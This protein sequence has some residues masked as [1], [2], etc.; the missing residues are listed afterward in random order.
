MTPKTLFIF[1]SIN[2]QRGRGL[3]TSLYRTVGCVG[4]GPVQQMGLVGPAKGDIS[5]MCAVP[6]KRKTATFLLISTAHFCRIVLVQRIC[7]SSKIHSLK[8]TDRENSRRHFITGEPLAPPD[9]DI[10]HRRCWVTMW[11]AEAAG[12]GSRHSA[13]HSGSPLRCS[14]AVPALRCNSWK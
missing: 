11:A 6:R 1:F 13:A 12:G 5:R 2:W 10:G 9:T 3:A 8:T 4:G 14:P 7:T